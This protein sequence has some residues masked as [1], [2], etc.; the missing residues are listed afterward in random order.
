MLEPQ[1]FLYTCFTCFTYFTNVYW[2]LRILHG[3]T[4][5]VQNCKIS[6]KTVCVF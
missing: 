6:K 4:V 3:C 5:Y 1:G 2:F